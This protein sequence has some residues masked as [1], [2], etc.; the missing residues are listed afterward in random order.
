MFEAPFRLGFWTAFTATAT[1]D[2]VLLAE[3]RTGSDWVFALPSLKSDDSNSDLGSELSIR[4]ALQTADDI[5]GCW[6]ITTGTGW[7]VDETVAGAES[8]VFADSMAEAFPRCV[9]AAT[10]SASV[11]KDAMDAAWSDAPN[12]W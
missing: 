2:D 12:D 7:S 10:A 1:V 9:F 5:I 4:L 8:A 3:F 11:C 6:G